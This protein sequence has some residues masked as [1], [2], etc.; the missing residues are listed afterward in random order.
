MPQKKSINDPA[1]VS[2]RISKKLKTRAK[3]YAAK[4]EKD[5][6]EVL[7]DAVEEYL[8]KRGA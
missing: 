7:D 8:N 3:A 4:A 2:V 6:R 1:L 5:L